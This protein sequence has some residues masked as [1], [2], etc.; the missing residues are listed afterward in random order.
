[1]YHKNTN[2]NSNGSQC[3]QQSNKCWYNIPKTPLLELNEYQSY[4]LDSEKKLMDFPSITSNHS[5]YLRGAFEM[6]NFKTPDELKRFYSKYMFWNVIADSSITEYEVHRIDE[7][8]LYKTE[9]CPSCTI[10]LYYKLLSESIAKS[11]KVKFVI[12]LG[13][14]DKAVT[15]LKEAH[16]AEMLMFAKMNMDYM[17]YLLEINDLDFDA[18]FWNNSPG[19][20]KMEVKQLSHKA[21]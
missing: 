19:K 3:E 14:D 5:V 7:H 11:N 15:N 16:F 6:H 12:I 13:K 1:M 17:A 10:Q 21:A 8:E 9:K 20:N 18:P 2:Q 4:C